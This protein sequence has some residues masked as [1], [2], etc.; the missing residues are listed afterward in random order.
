VNHDI[1]YYTDGRHCVKAGDTENGFSNVQF[2]ERT[3]E[4]HWYFVTNR[5]TVRTADLKA[6]EDKIEAATRAAG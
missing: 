6:T 4:G 2:V 1:Y 3:R 5:E